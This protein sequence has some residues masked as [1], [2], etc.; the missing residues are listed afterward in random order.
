MARPRMPL[1]R[2][3]SPSSASVPRRAATS[4]TSPVGALSGRGRRGSALHTQRGERHAPE[5][6]PGRGAAPQDAPL[7]QGDPARDPS[8]GTTRARTTR[9]AEPSACCLTSGAACPRCGLRLRRAQPRNAL[10]A[11]RAA[12]SRFS[13]G[14]WL[15][16]HVPL[17]D[18]RK[19][20]GD[21]QRARDARIP[22]ECA[23]LHERAC[24]QR[25]PSA[26]WS[27]SRLLLPTL[28]VT[29]RSRRSTPRSCG[30]ST[31]PEEC[32][33]GEPFIPTDVDVLFDEPTVAFRGP[34]NR[35]DLV[36]IAPVAT[37]LAQ[38]VRAPP[39]LSRRSARCR[40]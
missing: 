32:G 40:L 28:R 23:Y 38:S 4:P 14:S 36:K 26:R 22:R 30:S 37:D 39:R 27:S 13:P 18:D 21:R 3:C 25:S 8:Q 1:T 11:A 5:H 24:S 15:P 16:A 35:T 31:Q 9:A 7:G 34:W 19:Q 6:R 12:L 29:T 20:T 17:A 2:R 33:P 10:R